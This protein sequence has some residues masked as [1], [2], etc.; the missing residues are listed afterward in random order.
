MHAYLVY[1]PTQ[2]VKSLTSSK[3]PPRT[4]VVW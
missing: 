4:G 2:L 1:Q 3:Q